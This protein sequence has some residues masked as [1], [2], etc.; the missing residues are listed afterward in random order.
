MK[1]VLFGVVSLVCIL[2]GFIA[3]TQWLFSP[4]PVEE[5][6]A[7]VAEH[8]ALGKELRAWRI[9]GRSEGYFQEK[10]GYQ[11]M[12]QEVPEFAEFDRRRKDNERRI[13]EF[14]QRHPEIDRGW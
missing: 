8:I 13:Q 14:K 10:N 1:K 11:R 12:V 5:Q 2:A 6:K 7:L 3:L 4:S 9:Y